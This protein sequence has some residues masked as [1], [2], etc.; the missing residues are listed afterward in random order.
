MAKVVVKPL[1]NARGMSVQHAER[2]ARREDRRRRWLATRDRFER[3]YISPVHRAEV[4]ACVL[5]KQQELFD[6][7]QKEAGHA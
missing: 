4:R 1:P 6:A 5:R 2:N 3:G 7:L